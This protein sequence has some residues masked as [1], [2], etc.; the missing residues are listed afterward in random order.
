MPVGGRPSFEEELTAMGKE[1]VIKKSIYLT[2]LEEKEIKKIGE[3]VG[4][5]KFP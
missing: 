5:K 4:V 1:I 3:I 2:L